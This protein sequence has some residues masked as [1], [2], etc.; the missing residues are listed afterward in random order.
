MNSVE[1]NQ[2]GKALTSNSKK[3][4]RKRRSSSDKSSSR[5]F[6]FF[7]SFWQP[8]HTQFRHL[9]RGISCDDTSRFDSSSQQHYNLT[10]PLCLFLSLLLLLFSFLFSQKECTLRKVLVYIYTCREREKQHKCDEINASSQE[11]EFNTPSITQTR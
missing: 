4:K 8:E 1:G 2:K 9:V 11:H 5:R 10:N 3:K 7:L 6:F